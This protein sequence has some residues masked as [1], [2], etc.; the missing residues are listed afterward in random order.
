MSA[1]H[2]PWFA[3]DE[4]AR[5][6]SPGAAT[7]AIREALRAGLDPASDP[8]RGVVDLRSG[9]LLLMPSQRQATL[10]TSGSRSHVSGLVPGVEKPCEAAVRLASSTHTRGLVRASHVDWLADLAMEGSARSVPGCAG[11]APATLVCRSWS[12]EWASV[13]GG[14]PP[15]GLRPNRKRVSGLRRTL[16]S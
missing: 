3:A 14:G 10:Q 1:I 12:A 2:L 11:A 9:Q 16:R 13:L 8:T 6:L 5:L 4:I 7:A 15:S